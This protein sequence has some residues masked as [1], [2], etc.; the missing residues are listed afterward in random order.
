LIA[1]KWTK[2]S[3]ITAPCIDELLSVS[4]ASRRL[5]LDHGLP[6]SPRR[7]RGWLKSGRLPSFVDAVGRR[8]VAAAD[9]AAAVKRAPPDGTEAP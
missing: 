2:R 9:L 1:V 4:Q 7:L 6:I 3:S 8:Y 5:E